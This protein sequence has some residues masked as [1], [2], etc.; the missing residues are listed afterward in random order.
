M[1]ENVCWFL[2]L[3]P[4]LVVVIF[5][6]WMQLLRPHQ[7]ERPNM[8][9]SVNRS[10]GAMRQKTGENHP[11]KFSVRWLPAGIIW[12]TGETPPPHLLLS[13][14]FPARWA[15]WKAQAETL[16]LTQPLRDSF[17]SSL[18]MAPVIEPSER[19][20]GEK[21]SLKTER[22]GGGGRGEGGRW[23]S[24]KLNCNFGAVTLPRAAYSA[25][26]SARWTHTSGSPCCERTLDQIQ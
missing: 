21:R 24:R 6:C 1:A 4:Y 13:F 5:F 25:A 26:V 23:E 16:L 12:G 18:S 10:L 3:F 17:N 7:A 15:G 20:R 11:A 9:L 22:R 14:R 19:Q 8:A 2:Y